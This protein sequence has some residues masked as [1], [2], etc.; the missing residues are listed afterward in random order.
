MVLQ[1][2]CK[3]VKSG[4]TEVTIMCILTTLTVTAILK[5]LRKN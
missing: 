5:M 2:Y 1:A 3:A 4:V